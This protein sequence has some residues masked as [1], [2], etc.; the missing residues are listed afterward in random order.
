M[1][2]ILIASDEQCPT[3]NSQVTERGVSKAKAYTKIMP[4]MSRLLS[5]ITDIGVPFGE[6]FAQ[7]IE[8]PA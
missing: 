7:P 4:N 3:R 1:G 8:D 6:Q 2:R 5:G